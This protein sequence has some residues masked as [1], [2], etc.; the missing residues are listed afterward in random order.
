MNL[1]KYVCLETDCVGHVFVLHSS[2][3]KLCCDAVCAVKPYAHFK[4]LASA[5]TEKVDISV[6]FLY[7]F[8]YKIFIK[9][10]E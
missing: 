10:I 7:F 4:H 2:L 6:L 8:T 9:I 1:L 3:S 5:F